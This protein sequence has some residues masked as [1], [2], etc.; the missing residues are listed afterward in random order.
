MAGWARE[1]HEGE[2]GALHVDVVQ[3]WDILWGML[4]PMV[5][6]AA[7]LGG[8]IVAMTLL[9]IHLVF[10]PSFVLQLRY[11]RPGG[12]SHR[13]RSHFSV[14]EGILPFRASAVS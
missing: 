10:Y 3:R 1:A 7:A 14:L 12:T 5:R 9:A 13:S 8:V 11:L 4:S 6:G 2:T